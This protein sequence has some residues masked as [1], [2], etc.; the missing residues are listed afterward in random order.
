VQR[1]VVDANVFVS[2]FI[3]RNAAQ[4]AAARALLQSAE[5][6][7]VAAVVPQSV[8]FEVAYV[9]QSQYDVAGDRLAA[10][11]RAVTTFPGVHIVD[12]CSWKRV[13]EL[14]PNPLPGLADGAI[15]AV[16]TMNRYDAVATFDRKLANR[17]KDFGLAAF[18]PRTP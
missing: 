4:R 2:F 5:D 14:W 8:V 9:L 12:E 11:I 10:V 15:V 6:G 13:L 17:L 18:W 3:E 7:D 16:A 1:V